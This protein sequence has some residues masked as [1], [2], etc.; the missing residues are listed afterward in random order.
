M[1][2]RYTSVM[3]HVPQKV[4]EKILKAITQ[5]AGLSINL[6]LTKNPDHEIFVT[7]LQRKKIEEAIAKGRKGM[8]IRF[9]KRQQ[10]SSR[11]YCR[12][13]GRFGGESR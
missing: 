8:S 1:A 4:H 12:L 11:D 2:E 5:S 7:A 3:V 13:A 10:I 9:T 6:D